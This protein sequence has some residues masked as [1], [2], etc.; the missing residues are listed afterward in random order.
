MPVQEGK[1]PCVKERLQAI[2]LLLDEKTA[3]EVSSILR[4]NEKTIRR[5]AKARNEKKYEGSKPWKGQKKK[6]RISEEEWRKI[7]RMAIDKKITLKEVYVYIW[8]KY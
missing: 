6:L 5:W 1:D 7:G 4:H 8:D 2:L 3:I